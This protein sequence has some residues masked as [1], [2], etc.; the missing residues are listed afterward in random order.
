M[1]EDLEF[2]YEHQLSTSQ[3]KPTKDNDQSAKLSANLLSTINAHYSL[4]APIL[5]YHLL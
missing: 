3:V 4:Y 5:S 1:F 2:S